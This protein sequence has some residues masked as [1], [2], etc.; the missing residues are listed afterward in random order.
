MYNILLVD[1]EENILK[2]LQRTLGRQRDWEIEIYTRAEEALQR[3]RVKNFELVLSDYRMPEMDG[4]QFLSQVKQLQPDAARLIIS[5]YTDLDAL[6]GAINEASIYRF[7]SKP[8]NDYDLVATLEHALSY[9]DMQVENR[10]LADQVREQRQ[11]LNRQQA[12]LEELEAKYPGI[13]QVDR[14]PDGSIRLDEGQ[15]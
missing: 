13:T 9:R 11:Q 8:W 7:I 5:G 14:A 15:I 12:A 4:V 3:M 2:A 10:R 1:D 6:L